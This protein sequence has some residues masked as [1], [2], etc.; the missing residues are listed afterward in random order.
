MFRIIG[1][2]L[3]FVATSVVASYDQ[4][5]EVMTFVDE[6]VT[7]HQFDREVL[8]AAFSEAEKKES[9]L[10]AISR[11]AE[12]RL[13]WKGYRKIFLTD[14]RI[15]RGKDFIREHRKTLEKAQEKFGVP[16]EVIAAI[17]GV[18]TRYGRNKGSYRVVDA[19]STLAFDYPPRS[20]FFR[21]E[22]KQAF[23]LA[24]EQGFDV[25]NLKGSYAG[26]MGF[27]Q[28]IPSS[29]RHYAIDF[30]GD[31]VAD[32]LDNP[33]DAIGS[34]ANY[35]AEHR[36]KTGGKVAA[37]VTVSGST[38]DLLYKELKPR[39]VLADLYRQG[40]STVE[41]QDPEQSAKLL[42]LQGEQGEEFWATFHNFY[43]ITR[44]NHSHLYAMA[45]YQ[46]SQALKAE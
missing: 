31:N 45:V 32:I 27:G 41:G 3:L 37:P 15:K 14:D 38:G 22:L 7:E 20:K 24:R 46:L 18:E 9:I 25:L 26:A 28:F 1:L 33:T 35:F 36:W 11:P 43:V 10:K 12:K 16:V 34:V 8:I 6:L 17:I 42:R 30:D 2:G 40:V 39:H 23:L 5:P 19:L 29:Y 13:E 21:K 44:Y 4:R